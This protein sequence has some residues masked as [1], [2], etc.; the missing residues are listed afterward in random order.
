MDVEQREP[1]KVGGSCA[2]FE[3]YQLDSNVSNNGMVECPLDQGLKIS[4]YIS[5]YLKTFPRYL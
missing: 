2:L 5:S 3:R 1:G 4:L